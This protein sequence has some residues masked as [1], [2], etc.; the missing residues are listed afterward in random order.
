MSPAVPSEGL[1]LTCDRDGTVRRLLHYSLGAHAASWPGRS[2]QEL[3][4]PGSAEKAGL[5]L[6]ELETKGAALN[7]E[8]AMAVT[9]SRFVTL[10]CAASSFGGRVIVVGARTLTGMIA[11]F[12]EL[13]RPGD[14]AAAAAQALCE[15]WAAVESDALDDLTRLNNE[16]ATMKRRLAKQ[17][18]R[19]ERLDEQKNRFL[20][21]AAHDLRSPLGV[22]GSF[23]ELLLRELGPGLSSRHRELLEAIHSS[24]RYMLGLANDLLDVSAIESGRLELDLRPTD[25]QG[26]VE[27]QAF[28]N[29]VFAERKSIAIEVEAQPDLPLAEVD[30]VKIE[31]VLNNLIGNAV[32]FSKTGTTVRVSLR[33]GGAEQIEIHVRDQGQ[34]I[35]ADEL[36]GLFEAFRRGSSRPT[37]GESSSGLGLAIARRIV[38]GHGGRLSVESEVGVGSTFTV[39][40]RRASEPAPAEAP[41][42]ASTSPEAACGTGRPLRVLIAEDSP[43][44]RKLVTLLLEKSG[45][46]V[47]EAENGRQALARVSADRFDVMLI[48]I[49]MPVMGGLEATRELR[50]LERSGGSKPLPVV[51]LTGHSDATGLGFREA[52]INACVTKPVAAEPLFAALHELLGDAATTPTPRP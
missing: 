36:D 20:G 8:L 45:H 29:R 35:P 39:S 9:P 17:N 43:F 49:E 16:L 40:L 37:A 13:V 3:W 38:D 34:G 7:W 18:R 6:A 15:R 51:A 32:K 14:P 41:T 22:V 4:A 31:Q 26:L 23:S 46:C 47:V 27:R 50:R 24:S 42:V 44:C 33:R 52:G 48:D 19:L 25:L 11:L 30:A 5:M 10:R 28:F 21:M 12:L 1:A 2:F